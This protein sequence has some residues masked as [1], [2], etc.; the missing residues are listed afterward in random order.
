MGIAL[1]MNARLILGEDFDWVMSTVIVST[2]IAEAIAAFL[3][4]VE[5]EAV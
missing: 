2:V 1:A 4:D 3:P 5:R